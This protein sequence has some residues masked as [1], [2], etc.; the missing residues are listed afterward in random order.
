M[1][2]A[3]LPTQKWHYWSFFFPFCFFQHSQIQVA[4]SQYGRLICV[5][6]PRLVTPLAPQSFWRSFGWTQGQQGLTGDK[7]NTR[8]WTNGLSVPGSLHSPRTRETTHSFLAALWGRSLG[9]IIRNSSASREPTSPVPRLGHRTAVKPHTREP[10][11]ALSALGIWEEC[12]AL[13]RV[14]AQARGGDGASGEG[15][16][17]RIN[18]RTPASCP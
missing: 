1:L 5:D 15:G 16:L 12:S 18:P 6:A 8:P 3:A 11:I 17:P 13:W 4:L 10:A 9:K 14:T 2:F 7:P